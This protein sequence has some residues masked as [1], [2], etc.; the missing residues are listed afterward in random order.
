MRALPAW[1]A[2]FEHRLAYIPQH[3]GLA[4][5]KPLTMHNKTLEIATPYWPRIHFFA[6]CCRGASEAMQETT[7]RP[8]P[9]PIAPG[10]RVSL[11]S[12]EFREGSIIPMAATLELKFTRFST[13]DEGVLVVFCDEGLTFGAAS[14][15]ILESAGDLISRV[16]S[17]ER[18]KGKQGTTIDILAPNGLSVSRLVVVGVGKAG[19]L[20]SQDLVKLGGIAMG[21]LPAATT[22]A[23]IVADFPDGAPMSEAAADV[24]LGV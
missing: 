21:K 3:H 2:I 17:T 4:K 12:D 20:K 24:A 9:G 16:A 1:N 19:D 7:P 14:Q 11:P 22:Q 8:C 15:R 5:A 10:G 23:M 13:P 6:D 18:F